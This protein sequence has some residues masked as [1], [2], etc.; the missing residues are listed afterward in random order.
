VVLTRPFRA[1][2]GGKKLRL[3]TDYRRL[4]EAVQ[5]EVHP[6]TLATDLIKKIDPESR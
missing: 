1:K 5:R 4:N 2:T 6:F 3:V